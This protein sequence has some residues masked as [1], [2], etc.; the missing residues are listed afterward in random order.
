MLDFKNLLNA[1]NE[2]F[3]TERPTYNL[4]FFR[5][6][7]GTLIFLNIL[8][9][10]GN[11]EDFWGPTGMV[12][13][14]VTKNY[15]GFHIS[16]FQI[17]QENLFNTYLIY[18]IT[19]IFLFLVTIGL[20]TRAALFGA[21]IGIISLHMRNIWILSSADVLI[22][23]IFFILVWSPC[24]NVLSID[25]LIASKRKNPFPV[26]APQWTWRMLQIQICVVYL[27]TAWAKIKGEAW[28]DGS[29]VYYATRLETLKHYTLPWVLDSRPMLMLMTWA[30]LATELALGLLIWFNKTRRPVIVAGI[31]FHLGIEYVM[32]IP[33]F[34]WIMI[35][36]LLNFFQPEEYLSFYVK[37][38]TK[39]KELA[40]E[41]EI[42]EFKKGS[43]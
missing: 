31:L 23:C 41:L 42:K 8:V 24:Y 33:F 10:F 17:F 13:S 34:E 28:F 16:L 14:Q 3:F 2:F 27:W 43:L 1:W 6:I 36:L 40:A 35:V 7:W 39:W 22:R 30:S 21:L 29:A 26:E 11:V 12:S 19:L 37:M 20:F 18:F 5:I 4:A 9:E 32:A 25:S 38:K 15:L